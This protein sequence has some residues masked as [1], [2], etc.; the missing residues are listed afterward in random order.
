MLVYQK[1]GETVV[2]NCDNY[3]IQ[4]EWF[5]ADD[6]L[7][8]SL[9]F[10]HPQLPDML[11]QLSLTDK[12]SG[13]AF[14]I[15]KTDEGDIT[16]QIDLDEFRSEMYLNW[17]NNSDTAGGTILQVL[18]NGWT[19]LDN[20]QSSIRRTVKMEGATALE[21]L[22][23]VAN[24]YGLAIRFDRKAKRVLLENPDKIEPTGVYFSDELNLRKQ[25]VRTAQSKNFATRL[26]AVGKDGMTFADINDGKSYVDNN[27]YSNRIV[28]AYW[29]DDRYTVKENLLADAKKKL[30]EMAKPSQS[31]QCDV[32]DL[33]K[34]DPNQWAYL[35]V[36]MYQGVVLMDR[37]HHKR[38]I[39]RVV[40][41]RKYPHYPEKNT[42]TLSTLPGIISGKVEQS[43]NATTNPNSSFQQI[44][45]G[46]VTGLVDGIAGYD[47]GNLLITKN[48]QGKP[49]GFMIMDTES[50]ATAQKILWINLKGILYSSQGMAGFDNPNPEKITVWSFDKNGFYA[51]WLVIG[52]IDAGIVRV[53]NLIADHVQSKSGSYMM[54]LW[55]A[56]LKLM[57]G[58]NLRVRLYTTGAKE[59]AGL[60]QVFSGLIKED[61]TK[62][63]TTRYSFLSPTALG[64]GET[65][66]GTYTGTVNAGNVKSKYIQV[67]PKAG[68]IVLGG[69]NT[70]VGVFIDGFSVLGKYDGKSKLSVDTTNTKDI[71][72]EKIRPNNTQNTLYTNW[73]RGT[74]LTQD[75]WVLV[76]RTT[77]WTAKE[78]KY[79][80]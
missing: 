65:Q 46:F 59:S 19:L 33:A 40:Q 7:C 37:V 44:W 57:D 55:A 50:Q 42:V 79:A 38:L 70:G 36:E 71:N 41:Y 39:H 26:Y 76:G 28:S 73:K 27:E 25:P 1:N 31:Y 34:I 77:P 8:F 2:L 10:N 66:D 3:Y 11:N 4:E 62:D 58:E 56:V 30:D 72:L 60:L 63:E 24:I 6:S 16:A 52:T 9:G 51:N 67:E 49:N 61:G 5:G 18:P 74:E 54:E 17:T 29:S 53:I 15:T 14:L 12:E 22:R 80:D 48:S 32:V 45:K 13:Q 69:I 47:G 43:H 78:V 21:I 75:D 68:R 35:T 64:V 23:E 20:S